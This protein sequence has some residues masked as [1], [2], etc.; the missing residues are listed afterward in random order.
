MAKRRRDDGKR[1]VWREVRRCNRISESAQAI[2]DMSAK[3]STA[4][5]PAE[6]TQLQRQIDA[7]DRQ[8]DRLVYELYELSDDE[9]KIVE[10]ATA[11]VK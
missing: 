1:R 8:L 9:S 5:T 4:K 2:I 6:K 7:T 10:D 11:D 3:L